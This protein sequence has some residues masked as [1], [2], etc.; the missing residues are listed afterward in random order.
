MSNELGEILEQVIEVWQ[1]PNI[2]P[3]VQIQCK[4][5]GRQASIEDLEE[6]AKGAVL[7]PDPFPLGAEV[8]RLGLEWEGEVVKNT[9]VCV[10]GTPHRHRRL[11]EIHAP[12]GNEAFGQIE[13]G[14]DNVSPYFVL[15]AEWEAR[16]QNE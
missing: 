16:Q 9:V 14:F 11:L 15:K 4:I 10:D 8:V 3:I 13:T 2:E 5:C 12:D 7:P 1:D 6:F